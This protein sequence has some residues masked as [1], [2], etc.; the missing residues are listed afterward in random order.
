M[1]SGLGSSKK[2]SKTPDA[3]MVT[4]MRRVY[5]QGVSDST[6][7]SDLK[8]NNYRQT[9]AV[10][11]SVAF[12]ST[13]ATF[14][15]LTGVSAPSG[16]VP[17]A[18]TLVS[19]TA[20]NT[21]LIIAFTAPTNDGG[22][23]ITD[24]EYSIDSGS[25]FTSA[26]VTTSPFTITGL[27]NGTSYSVVIRAVNSV[28]PSLSSNS[29][30]GTPVSSS[31]PLPPVLTG[32]SAK[33]DTSITITFTQSSNG[34]PA[35]TNYKYS[36]NGGAFTAF[37]P[38]DTTSP[39][40][41]S[42]L[43]M[44]TSYNIQLKSVNINGD[45]VES[46]DITEITYEVVYEDFTTIGRSTWTAPAGV[47]QIDYLVVG[48]G[49]GGG[50]SYSDIEVIGSV[51]F[52]T[53]SP[54]QYSYW[55]NSNP[56]PANP[57]YGFLYKGGSRYTASKP[58]RLTAPQNITPNGARY[59]YNKWYNFEIIYNIS[60][61]FP[62]ATNVVY[63]RGGPFSIYSNSHSAGGGGGGGGYARTSSIN[64]FT[65]FAVTPGT[66]YDIYVG[67]GGAGGTGGAGVE[68]AGTNGEDSYFDS[69]VALG[70]A[71][72]KGSRVNFN[73]NGGGGYDGF[74]NIIGGKGG[75]GGGRN[76]G[77]IITPEAYQTD[78]TL[79][80]GTYGGSGFNVNF[81]GTG[82]LQYSRG[83]D[84]GDATVVATSTTPANR[85]TGGEGTGSEL[86]SFASGIEGSSGVVR[87]KYYL[88]TQV[89]TTVGTTSWTAPAYTSTVS[90]LVVGG[91]GGAG[92]GYD[93][94]GGGGGG[95]GM[96]R[97]GSLSVTPGTVY[98]IT[99]GDGGI[100]GT[101]ARVDHAGTDGSESV[102]ASIISLGG[103]GGKASR[104]DGVAGIAQNLLSDPP[105]AP[106]GGSGSGG[107]NGGKGG[108]G[109]N[110]DGMSNSGTTGGSGGSGISSALSGTLVTYGEGGDGANSGVANGGDNSGAINTGT[111][112]NA[113]GSASSSSMGGGNGRAG[114]VVL[115]Y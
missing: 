13:S 40:T 20:G 19:I 41:V 81:D 6:Y 28:G 10:T 63:V 39:V 113:G 56:A 96:V 32:V 79:L 85:G 92:N 61:G 48:G 3:S 43:T 78:I 102:F 76:G 97:S 62:S 66:T 111:G 18:P 95:G 104:T 59:D 105:T 88:T 115:C 110:A 51:P 11:N 46:N 58:V 103:G 71:G 24:Y 33:T 86:N 91:G 31:P 7:V 37:S 16:T 8:K 22:S 55:I 82:P 101:N 100:G 52:Q 112:G 93:N 109:A 57:F 83:G 72:G 1:S 73:Q 69:V 5:A 21:E 50:A 23:A 36:L 87:I 90:Y 26:S 89:I 77:P 80:R 67:A 29:R 34:S 45:S 44:N 70:G 25:T 99:V 98:T 9:I 17:N 75:A 12:H 2:G 84:G 35:I 107:G 14:Q 108:G 15:S 47:S 54:G 38:A 68:N 4:R 74:G 106:T 60:N 94:A 49:G 114:I 30:S 65:K 64:P 42:G 53:T 27:T